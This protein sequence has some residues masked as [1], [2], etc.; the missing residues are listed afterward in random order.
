MGVVYLSLCRSPGHEAPPLSPDATD[1]ERRRWHA[2]R[3]A[4]RGP[5]YGDAMIGPVDQI[6]LQREMR[7]RALLDQQR[8]AWTSFKKHGS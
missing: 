6:Q 3:H 2:M 4:A 5:Q 8:S 1:E 7:R